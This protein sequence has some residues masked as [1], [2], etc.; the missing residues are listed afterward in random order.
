MN[1]SDPNDKE[2]AKKKMQRVQY[3]PQGIQDGRNGG[4]GLNTDEGT[5]D[6]ELM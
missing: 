6:N 5:D 3:S 1:S 2:M 4:G